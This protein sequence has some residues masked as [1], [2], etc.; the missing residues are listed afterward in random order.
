MKRFLALALCLVLL[1]GV[2]IA[3]EVSTS[4]EPEAVLMPGLYKQ[5]SVPVGFRT[6]LMDMAFFAVEYDL[7][8]RYDG[9][10]DDLSMT[11][12]S[13]NYLN[14]M[15]ADEFAAVFAAPETGWHLEKTELNGYQAHHVWRDSEPTCDGYILTDESEEMDAGIAYTLFFTTHSDAGVALRD[16]IISTLRGLSY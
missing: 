1:C 8:M 6:P 9:Q 7:G 11:I 5:L 4:F 2:A 12:W 3:D 15:T 13:Y 14:G 16:E 10:N